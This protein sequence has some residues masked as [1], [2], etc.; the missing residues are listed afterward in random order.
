[1]LK[2][3]HNNWGGCKPF[4]QQIGL[5]LLVILIFAGVVIWTL[6]HLP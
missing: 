2:D 6:T 4:L 1:M 5:I 3:Y